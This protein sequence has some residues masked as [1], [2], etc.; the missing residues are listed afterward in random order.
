MQK[1]GWIIMLSAIASLRK[2]NII[3]F[4]LYVDFRGECVC[5][6]VCICP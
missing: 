6:H 1:K 5:V 3:L 4:F 2:M